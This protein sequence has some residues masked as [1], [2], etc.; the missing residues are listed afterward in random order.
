MS[1]LRVLHVDDEPDIREV[2]ELALGLDPEL[3]IKSCGSGHDGLDTATAWSPDLILLDVMMPVMDGPTTLANLR[4]QPKTAA[5]P[6]V[7]MT[8]RA[9]ARELDHFVSLG[10]QGVIAKPFDP[11]TLAA[12][13][14]NY[15][16]GVEVGIANRRANF[17]KR[18]RVHA[19]ALLE[20][21]AALG[22]ADAN[23]ALDR[24]RTVAHTIAGTG[25]IFGLTM[26]SAAAAKLETAAIDRLEGKDADVEPA[27]DALVARIQEA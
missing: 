4:R 23:A 1:A 12:S 26:M 15:A 17:I 3:S 14:R 19:E 5:I 11:M 18:A 16:G 2:V 7:F 22:G 20:H 6:V 24:I 10:A 13:V 21:R 27:L 25:G 8:A 9:Q